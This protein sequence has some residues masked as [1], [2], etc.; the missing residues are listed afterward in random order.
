MSNNNNY[1]QGGGADHTGQGY[2]GSKNKKKNKGPHSN[3]QDEGEGGY[4]Y[5]LR[6]QR[7]TIGNLNSQNQF[8]KSRRGIANYCGRTLGKGMHALVADG[9]EVLPKKPERPKPKA[10]VTTRQQAEQKAEQES[11]LAAIDPFDMKDYDHDYAQY[12]KALERYKENK[13]KAFVIILGQCTD[14]LLNRL[15]AHEKYTK[16]YDDD[17][18]VGLLDLIKQLVATSN[19]EEYMCQTFQRLIMQYININM[20]HQDDVPFWETRLDSAEESLTNRWGDFV[21]DKLPEGETKETFKEKLKAYLCIKGADPKRYKEI[22]DEIHKNHITGAGTCPTTTSKAIA[23]LNG[24]DDQSGVPSKPKS[25]LKRNN[26]NSNSNSP[27]RREETSNAQQATELTQNSEKS[28]SMRRSKRYGPSATG[29][30][31]MDEPKK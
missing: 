31:M 7:F 21:P 4:I 10:Q 17:D 28:G 3:N 29:I 22:Q 8:V 23:M 6:K 19:E 14:K 27:P 30:F 2:K 16:L 13:G 12:S 1:N 11:S 9:R 26:S 15:K 24:A 20:H 25:I 18:V 5:E